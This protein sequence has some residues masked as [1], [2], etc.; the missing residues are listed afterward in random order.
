[1]DFTYVW[2]TVTWDLPLEYYTF[3]YAGLGPY[4]HNEVDIPIYPDLDDTMHFEEY[5]FEFD[6]YGTVTL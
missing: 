3:Y 2:L 6:F 4:H 5:G 1:L